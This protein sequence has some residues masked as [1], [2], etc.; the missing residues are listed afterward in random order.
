VNQY[1][2]DWNDLK[3]YL[4]AAA[5]GV[6]VATLLLAIKRFA[7]SRFLRWSRA[8]DRPLEEIVLNQLRP[9][10]NAILFLIAF[11]F[12]LQLTPVE[13]RSHPAVPVT[14]KL[15]LVLALL[16]MVYR[17]LT[18]V[19]EYWKPIKSLGANSR[20]LVLTISRALLIALTMLIILDVLGVSITPLLASLGVGSVAVALAAQDTL[21]NFFSGIYI[22]IDK[23]IQPGEYIKLE[24]GVMEGW[25]R[26][27]GWRSSQIETKAGDMIIM[28]NSRLSSSILTNF[29]FPNQQTGVYTQV[30]VAYD[31]DLQK[32]ETVVMEV[33]KEVLRRT[34]GAVADFNPIVRFQTF[35]ASSIDLE[36]KLQAQT[37]ADVSTVKHEFMKALHARFTA[38]KIEIPFPQQVVHESKV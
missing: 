26:K 38:E 16:W 11:S 3:Q 34:P 7:W 9:P 10:L 2:T 5:L 21:S 8:S 19:M 29:N 24:G 22:L 15:L 27:I 25:V 28:P 1:L 23:P 20:T 4:L 30:G 31:S 36:A 18:V 13:L 37:Q 6:A 12:G 17:A 14:T 33:A 35:A 32:V